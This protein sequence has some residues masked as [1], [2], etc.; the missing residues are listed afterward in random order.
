M[1]D[2]AR[3]ATAVA[4][5]QASLN[6]ATLQKRPI[7]MKFYYVNE[8]QFFA[9]TKIRVN[10]LRHSHDGTKKVEYRCPHCLK[11]RRVALRN[12]PCYALRLPRAG[13]VSCRLLLLPAASFPFVCVS[14]LVVG[15]GRVLLLQ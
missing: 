7:V 13:L 12:C 1:V 5:A 2:A 11:V 8:E 3:P 10:L 9:T 6:N 14:C 4:T 15:C